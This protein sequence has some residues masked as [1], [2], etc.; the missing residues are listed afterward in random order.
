MKILLLLLITSCAEVP[1]RNES[2]AMC[3]KQ[4]MSWQLEITQ[5]GDTLSC[6]DN[7]K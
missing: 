4:Q 7:S 2:I 3:T 1:E 6:V 5:Y